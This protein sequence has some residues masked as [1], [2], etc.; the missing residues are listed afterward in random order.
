MVGQTAHFALR[1][2]HTRLYFFTLIFVFTELFF[3]M[4]SKS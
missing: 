2:L 4:V 1:G 3:D